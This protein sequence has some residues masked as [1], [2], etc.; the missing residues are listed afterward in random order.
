MERLS[1][2]TENL[3]QNN[4]VEGRDLNLLPPKYKAGLPTCTHSTV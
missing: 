1:K 2:T 4:Q 3:S